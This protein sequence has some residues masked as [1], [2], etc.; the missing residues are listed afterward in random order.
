MQSFLN[1]NYVTV[2]QYLMLTL[3]DLD[4]K[5]LAAIYHNIQYCSFPDLLRIH[6]CFN[7]NMSHRSNF[8]Y[9]MKGKPRERERFLTW[10]LEAYSHHLNWL[11]VF[12][13]QTPRSRCLVPAPD[14]GVPLCCQPG[15]INEDLPLL[16]AVF[17]ALF[18]ASVELSGETRTQV[19]NQ[20]FGH[21]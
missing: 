9:L 6:W 16:K 1:E 18:R 7:L 19:N 11:L 17:G 4:I 15:M 10:L 3:L 8:R 13:M 21:H 20:L 2:H 12:L 14:A 5:N